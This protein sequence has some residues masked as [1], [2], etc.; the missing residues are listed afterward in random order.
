MKFRE[1]FV[2]NSSSSS[3]LL[4]RKGGLTKEQK[5]AI[6][7]WAEHW[8]FGKK[9][10][11]PEDKDRWEK[12][13]DKEYISEWKTEEGKKYLEEGFSLWRGWLSYEE[14]DIMLMRLYQSIWDD[15]ESKG[16]FEILDGDLDY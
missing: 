15:L 5:D 13:A 1:D 7:A 6:I 8:F 3:F 2:T 4:A 9:I 10:A 16:S 12:I 11:G 14:A